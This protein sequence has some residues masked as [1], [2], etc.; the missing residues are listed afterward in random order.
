MGT[1]GGA[2]VVVLPG[3]AVGE[4]PRGGETVRLGPGL[5]E[6]GGKI[7][8]HTAGVLRRDPRAGRWWVEGDARRYHAHPGDLVVGRVAEVRGEE[9]LVDI[10]GPY[11]ASLP[12]LAFEGATRRNKPNLKVADAVHAR[13]EFANRDLDPVLTCVDASTGKAKGL[14]HLKGGYVLKCGSGLARKLLR[15]PPAPVLA[16]LGETIPYELAVGVNGWVWV[17]AEAPADTILVTNALKN[18]EDLPDDQAELL[19][20]TLMKR[21]RAA[22]AAVEEAG[23]TQ[24]VD[25]L[26]REAE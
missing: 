13:V 17:K 15:W 2:G 18:S 1:G 8:A 22:A 5:R 7:V 3:D 6:A 4:L 25:E 20:R 16:A 23:I 24:A 12:A 21:Q 14:G 10:G 11:P 19:V 9:F 26:M